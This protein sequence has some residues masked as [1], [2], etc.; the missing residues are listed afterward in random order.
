MP[1]SKH[2]I[3]VPVK[4]VDGQWEF[5]YGGLV[6]VADGAVGELHLDRAHF[7]DKDFLTIKPDLDQSLDPYLLEYCSTPHDFN[8]KVTAATQFVQ[9]WLLGPSKAQFKQKIG[10]GG[11]SLLLE[12]MEPRGIETGTVQLPK[13]HGLDVADSLNHAFT[14]LS[15]VFEPWR[16]AH[17]GSIY[18]RVFYQE[19]NGCWY[20]LDDLRNLVLAGAERKLIADL[21][22]NVAKELRISWLWALSTCDPAEL[23]AGRC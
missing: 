9:V 7:K 5:F 10:F 1:L 2:I 15:E 20:P 17:T 14:R 11:L 12:G 19:A 22:K 18:E 21:R 16:K 23:R 6:K 8:A 3:R 13:T 4:L